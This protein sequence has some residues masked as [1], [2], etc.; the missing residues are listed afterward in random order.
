MQ[1]EKTVFD[2]R[3]NPWQKKKKKKKRGSKAQ[4]LIGAAAK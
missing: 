4:V 1:R 2:D 3:V